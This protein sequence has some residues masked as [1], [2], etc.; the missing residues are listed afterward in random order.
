[1]NRVWK[2]EVDYC[3]PKAHKKPGKLEDSLVGERLALV[4]TTRHP[5]RAPVERVL[6]PTTCAHMN[7]PEKSTRHLPEAEVDTALRMPARLRLSY[8]L[9]SAREPSSGR[10]RW[11]L[12][13]SSILRLLRL[14]PSVFAN[15]SKNKDVGMIALCTWSVC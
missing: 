5:R 13:G 11:H 15:L 8:R 4:G 14:R 2:Q 1:M 12:P 6:P 3:W 7:Q 9:T 10:V